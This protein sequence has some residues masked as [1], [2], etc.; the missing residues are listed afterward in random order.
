VRQVILL[1][2][3]T[4]ACN[5]YDRDFGSAP[6]LCG[7]TEPRCPKD[8]TCTTDP[9]TGDE[10]CANGPLPSFACA[11]DSALEPNETVGTASPTSVDQT[12]MVVLQD[13]AICP[14]GDKDTFAIALTTANQIALTVVYAPGGAMLSGAITGS[15]GVALATATPVTG[16]A[17]TIHA[18]TSNLPAGQYYARVFG[19]DTGMPAV[20]NYTLTIAVP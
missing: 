11:D 14:A 8:Y 17:N 5:A 13:L 19:P 6:F 10:V 16:M 18:Q 3:A 9:T 4:T 15:D 20:N 12:K 1:L 7:P 2:I